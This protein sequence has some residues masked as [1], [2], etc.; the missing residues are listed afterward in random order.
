MSGEIGHFTQL[1]WKNSVNVGIGIAYMYSESDEN[2]YM[3][4]VAKYVPGGNY[5]NQYVENVRPRVTGKEK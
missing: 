3:W 5:P 2:Y 1:V 4:T